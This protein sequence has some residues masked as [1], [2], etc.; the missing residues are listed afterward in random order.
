MIDVAPTIYL[1]I[2]KGN[3]SDW[4]GLVNRSI[5]INAIYPVTV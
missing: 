5:R 3:H 1:A 4:R 2:Y